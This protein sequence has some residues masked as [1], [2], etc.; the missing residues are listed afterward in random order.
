ML[1]NLKKILNGKKNLF[2]LNIEILINLCCYVFTTLLRT[3]ASSQR[4]LVSYYCYNKFSTLNGFQQKKCAL[5]ESEV[6][7]TVLQSRCQPDWFL[8]EALKGESI[9]LL[10][11]FLVAACI[12]W[13]QPLLISKARHSDFGFLIPSPSH[14]NSP[15]FLSQ[16]LLGSHWTHPDNSGESPHFKILNFITFAKSLCQTK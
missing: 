2:S 3:L 12:L 10:F 9:S 11:Q 15:S 7:F 6:S 5:L 13:L 14:S 16:R 8:W 4:V 1:R